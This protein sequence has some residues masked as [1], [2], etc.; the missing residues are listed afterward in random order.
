MLCNPPGVKIKARPITL[1]WLTVSYGDLNQPGL[2]LLL[3]VNVLFSKRER[4]DFGNL[5]G[6]LIYEIKD[7]GS[8]E[9][10]WTIADK[11]GVG[12]ET[13]KPMR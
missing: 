6:L 8:L 9:G 13:L 2:I 12:T 11:S 4:E 7:D 10:T 1:K 5:S 3:E